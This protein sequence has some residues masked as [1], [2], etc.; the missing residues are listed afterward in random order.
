MVQYL[1]VDFNIS[2]LLSSGPRSKSNKIFVAYRFKSPH[3]IA[4]RQ[5]IETKIKT[6]D[7]LKEIDVIDGHVEGGKSWA[8][9]IRRR[10]STSKLVVAD[11]TALS[12]EV[13]FECGFAWGLNKIIL[14]VV[15][16]KS[17]LFGL[18]VWLTDLQI[19]S[20]TTDSECNKV[21]DAISDNLMKSQRV[22]NQKGLN[23]PDPKKAIWIYGGNEFDVYRQHLL[24]TAK[25]F[26]LELPEEDL[27]Q[28]LNDADENLINDIL[29]SSLIIGFVNNTQSDS[30]IHFATGLVMSKPLAG[31][32]HNKIRRKVI[33]AI[34]RGLNIKD[35]VADSAVRCHTTVK[36]VSPEQIN[37]ELLN[38]AQSYKSYLSKVTILNR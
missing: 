23:K 6:S 34:Q 37:N 5:K 15:K 14:P 33:L 31:D 27:P 10:L 29:K 9:E 13:L 1:I 28:S 38:F 2:D 32:A 17:K 18:P 36:V 16:D 19:L 22:R 11:L 24:Q 3:S 25:R 21:L 12:P 26:E 30:F 20:Y 8:S 7:S 35:V 4:F